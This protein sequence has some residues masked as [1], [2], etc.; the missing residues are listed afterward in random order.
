MK[1]QNKEKNNN[2]TDIKLLYR[3]L[4]KT[5]TFKCGNFLENSIIYNKQ[6]VI[7][8]SDI[9]DLFLGMH[10]K[11]IITKYNNQYFIQSSN[12]SF[13]ADKNNIFDF[14]DAFKEINNLIYC[15][16]LEDRICKELYK[17]FI[18][19]KFVS[20]IHNDNFCVICNLE[21]Y[22]QLNNNNEEQFYILK[23]IVQHPMMEMAREYDAS[24][25]FHNNIACNLCKKISNSYGI[26]VYPSYI[27]YNIGVA[28]IN[29]DILIV[30]QIKNGL[31][32][33]DKKEERLCIK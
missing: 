31:L 19:N 28:Y 15:K 20:I 24:I 1:K 13:K 18:E 4:N 8:T 10:Y 9:K 33:I 23:Y 7:K 3:N 12:I 27:E 22:R 16:D 6:V 5:D 21:C 29:N 17:Q 26:T 32:S 14:S 25:N 2:L 11:N 30:N